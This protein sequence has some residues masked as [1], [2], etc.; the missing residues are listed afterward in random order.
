ML[1]NSGLHVSVASRYYKFQDAA[2]PAV[3]PDQFVEPTWSDYQAGH[4]AVLT[5]IVSHDPL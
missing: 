4:D 1:P 5:W 2:T 3:M